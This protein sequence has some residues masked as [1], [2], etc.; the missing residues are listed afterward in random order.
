MFANYY[1]SV[2]CRFCHSHCKY[3]QQSDRL[4]MDLAGSRFSPRCIS[5]IPITLRFSS[6]LLWLSPILSLSID[7]LGSLWDTMS[8]NE[9]PCTTCLSG[10]VRYSFLKAMCV[11]GWCVCAP[12]D[13][14]KNGL[15]NIL[16][17]QIL[18]SSSLS[19]FPYFS[20]EV[21]QLRSRSRKRTR[22]SFNLWDH[23]VS[24]GWWWEC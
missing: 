8:L 15:A 14:G 3:G 22:L 5:Q 16:H 11:C 6:T 18:L 13:R 20:T 2:S 1:D 10:S 21:W 9:P 4:H 23:V 24:T 17:W 19:I 12:R 7:S